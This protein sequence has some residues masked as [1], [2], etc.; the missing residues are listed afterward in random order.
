MRSLTCAACGKA[1]TGKY[2][3]ALG[4][5]WHVEHFVCARC[6]RVFGTDGFIEE[7]GRPF[8]TRCHDEAFRAKC[9][10][11]SQPLRGTYAKDLW[12][13]S[14]C[15][16][17]SNELATCDVCDRL[18]CTELTGGGFR[19]G[20]GRSVCS[21]CRQTAV[22]DVPHAASLLPSVTQFL[23]RHSVSLS[24]AEI[25][26]KLVDSHHLA[27]SSA[28]GARKAGET[29]TCV[30]ARGAT[31]T[32]REVV[33]VSILGGLPKA[34]FCA[35]AAHELGHA[36]L[37]LQCFPKLEAHVEEGICELLSYEWLQSSSGPLSSHLMQKI[38]LRD[39]DTYG[40]GFRLA[41]ESRQHRSVEQLLSIVRK[42]GRLPR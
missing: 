5:V 35:V 33:S 12:G 11:C 25:P 30:L 8:C 39:D 27:T 15:A 4:G 38:E 17:H 20:D 6:G 23:A 40:R 9:S 32:K 21:L 34:A 14:Y 28:G 19:Y 2:V 26:L 18:I 37:F 42:T 29:K 10:I 3:R 1:I 41:M 13:N 36:W 24:P 7:G 22:D 16:R 31:E